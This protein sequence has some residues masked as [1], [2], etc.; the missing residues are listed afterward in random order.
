M[1]K[2]TKVG[3]GKKVRGIK[4]SHNNCDNASIGYFIGSNYGLW[5]CHL[6]KQ[7]ELKTAI[8]TAMNDPNKAWLF[9]D[10]DIT[11]FKKFRHQCDNC[12]N[13]EVWAQCYLL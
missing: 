2:E 8:E 1:A 11:K 7:G 10:L 12:K 9:D 5:L 6:H 3:K 4:C 13:A